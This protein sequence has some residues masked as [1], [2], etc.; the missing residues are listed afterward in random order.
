MFENQQAAQDLLQGLNTMQMQAGFMPGAMPGM[1]PLFAPPPLAPTPADFSNSIRVQFNPAWQNPLPPPRMMGGI[2]P[3]ARPYDPLLQPQMPGPQFGFGY[4]T[5]RQS[6]IASNS[7]LLGGIQTGVGTAANLGGGLLAAGVGTALGG[8]LGGIAAG[9]AYDYLGVGDRLNSLAT[10]PMQPLIN[11]RNRALSLQQMSTGFVNRGPQLSAS[12]IGLNMGASMQLERSI[13]RLANNDIFQGETENRFNRADLMKISKLAGQFG[14]L[15][16]A[17][18]SDELARNL[19]SIFK[20]V[21]N[22]MKMAEEPDVQRALQTM[23]QMRSLGMTASS[24]N[25]AVQ[26]ARTFAR[27]AGVSTS[28]MLGTAMSQGAPMAQAMG[29][30]GAA[31][32]QM[33]MAAQGAAGAFASSMGPRQLA[34]AGGREGVTQSMFQMN[35][36]AANIDALL[37]AA[38]TMRDGQLQVDP[39][40]LRDLMS[41]RM[42]MNQALQQSV[43]SVGSMGMVG[44]QD[45]LSKDKG[46][47]RDQATRLMGPQAGMLAMYTRAAG[48]ADQ[49]G[50]TVS[51][52]SRL[53]GADE[54]GARLIHEIGRNPEF[55]DAMRQQAQQQ[56]VERAMEVQRGRGLTRSRA[57]GEAIWEGLGSALIDPGTFGMS[58]RETVRTVRQGYRGMVNRFDR[59]MQREFGEEQDIEE[60]IAAQGGGRLLAVSRGARLGT[61]VQMAGL[62]DRINT[63]Q[64]ANVPGLTQILNQQFTERSARERDILSPTTFLAP[65]QLAR[66]LMTGREGFGFTEISRGGANLSSTL[67]LSL[68]ENITTGGG[69]LL[70]DTEKRA[71][72]RSQMRLG[73]TLQRATQLPDAMKFQL[74][75]RMRARLKEKGVSGEDSVNAQGIA[76]SA[77][78]KYLNSRYSIIG[79]HDPVT[80]EGYTAEIRKALKAQGYTEDKINQLLAD[81]D[82]MEVALSTAQES[83][84]EKERT[85]QDSSQKKAEET[86]SALALDRINTLNDIAD[87]ARNTALATLGIDTDAATDIAKRELLDVLSGAGAEGDLNKDILRVEAL[88]RARKP[89]EALALEEQVRQKASSRNI[90]YVKRRGQVLSQISNVERDTLSELGKKLTGTDRDQ[91]LMS[92]AESQL[93][94]AAA[95]TLAVGQ[96]Q[97][98][99]LKGAEILQTQGYGAFVAAVR[100]GEVRGMDEQLRED[101][102]SGRVT[103][104]EFNVRASRYSQTQPMAA[105]EDGANIFGRGYNKVTGFIDDIQ[106]RAE[107][108]AKKEDAGREPQGPTSFNE[109]VGVF[110]TAS[111]QLLRAAE[112]LLDEGP[113]IVDYAVS[114]ADWIKQ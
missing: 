101:I 105:V 95:A 108:R 65:V 34:L 111:K 46:A 55:F 42:S 89:R 92:R 40:K 44:L 75:D 29:M 37:P 109:S 23:A 114:V 52:A 19:K 51:A 77:Y 13:S 49:T 79:A 35:M 53:L 33:H 59:F 70:S 47:L 63:G 94:Q 60:Q 41:G 6:A 45:L 12:G 67:D 66:A 22:F 43:S 86:Q 106:S 76:A 85:V 26:N 69:R 68:M 10:L 104:Q 24:M 54:R 61:A 72:F 18:S 110:N 71:R 7:G 113:S 103:E 87:T 14:M 31:G 25:N 97:M 112:K 82:F 102:V 57:R 2:T 98:I 28:E 27:M 36:N 32:M 16:D 58:G 81:K 64:V 93:G 20:G 30:T 5:G 11:Q 21:S 39:Q 48:I 91:A 90:D 50:M 3:V 84:T 62:Q 73:E 83:Q 4:N 56:E 78:N 88:K 80:P 1:R 9:M 15:S 100:R 96:Q 74:Q 17:Q 38:V 8:P 107:A 99:G